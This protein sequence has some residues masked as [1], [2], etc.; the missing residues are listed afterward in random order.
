MSNLNYGL[1]GNSCTAALIS[2][3][4]DM[5]WLCMP[6]FDSPS[7]FASLLDREKGGHFGIEPIGNY[8]IIQK[9]IPH[10][11]LLRTRFVSS[12]AEFEITDFM[13]LYRDQDTGEYYHPSEV[14]RYVHLIRGL[15]RLRFIY[16]PRP[17]YARGKCTLNI[18]DD[19]VES[20]SSS[21]VAD[22]QY[23]YSSF[24]LTDILKG[25]IIGL[26]TDGFFLLS[27]NEKLIHVDL[28]QEKLEYCRTL[29]YWLNWSKATK[30]Y[31]IYNDI[32]ERSLLTL[33]M[34]T[35]YNGAVLAAITTSLPE[36]PGEVRNWD[37]RFCWLRDASMTIETLVNLGHTR[38]AR[39]FVK[40]IQ[41]TFIANHSS[42][43]IMY[44]IHGQ[45]KLTEQTL[46]HLSGY[47]DSRP[48]R[49]GNAA[50]KQR[51]NDSFGYLMNMIYQY[52]NLVSGPQ[53]EIED[54][55]DMV[56]NICR[57][58]MSEWK[59]PDKGIWE[60]RGKAQHFV[61][62][63]V[64]CWVALDRGV[65]IAHRLHKY[66][67]EE[68][69]QKTADKIREDVMNKGWNE[70]LQ[71]FTQTYD[72][73]CIDASLLLLEPYGFI[74]AGNEKYKMTVNAVRK[75]LLHQGLVYRYNA[76]DDFGE[77]KSAFT[78]C[79]F[80]LIR[81][82][83]V[84]GKRQQ[85]HRLFENILK[86]ANHLGM[87]SEDIDLKTKALLGNYPQAYSHLALIN[88]A[89]LLSENEPRS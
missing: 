15:P 75:E 8:T 39:R 58:V 35:F 56:K 77:P 64:M 23:L 19:Y 24:P 40:F 65:R 51:Q 55:W 46:D 85:A 38:A 47:K 87:F 74:E 86:Y 57:I 25:N 27:Y 52:Y 78:I 45:R 31:P 1:I 26:E 6:Y 17:D 53:D 32:I 54:I 62:S 4:G 7:V 29:T 69:W 30:Q 34:M 20:R 70:T 3:R 79:T 44:S 10:T 12:D 71:T 72:N 2:E 81:A 88:T 89:I 33:K 11:N 41:S 50:W 67:E 21:N 13:P 9:Y 49:I 76:P 43:Q 60:I 63:K 14:Y 16:A 83:F 84:T 37:Y 66:R 42:F 73:T 68:I 5:E 59:N 82:L 80:W 28:E 18:T 22:R 61:S 36:Y 48:V